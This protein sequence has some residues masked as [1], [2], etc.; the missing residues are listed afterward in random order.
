[1]TR[2]SLLIT[3]VLAGACTDGGTPDLPPGTVAATLETESSGNDPDD[4]AIFVH[5]T[6]PAL[7]RIIA[8]D[9]GLGIFFYDLDGRIVDTIPDLA[10][11]NVDLRHRVDIGEESLVLGTT[12]DRNRDILFTFGI[13]DDGHPVE[14]ART[15]E[16]EDFGDLY[17]SCMYRS[18]EGVLYVFV[19][20]KSGEY[21]Q[22]RIESDPTELAVS[23]THVRTFSLEGQPEG[24]VADDVASVVYL[25]EEDRGLF[26]IGA[27][28]DDGTQVETVDL[29]GQGRLIA[30]VEGMTIYPTTGGG[31]YLLVSSQGSDE[32]IV[33]DRSVPNAFVARFRIGDGAATDA[34]TDTDGIDVSPLALGPNF[35][36]GVFVAQDDHDDGFSRNF[37]IVRWDDI[38]RGAT[39]P[40]TIDTSVSP[41]GP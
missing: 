39:S 17:G 27:E 32:F 2:R 34:A 40:L 31:G 29:V 12:V 30:D 23:F 36:S 13:D 14:V 11:N 37:K 15:G 33:Y 26:R 35:P 4:P 38:A 20:A 18:P 8:T 24:C 1:M 16:I 7:S 19:N 25:G 5:P 9:K 41:Y 21:R 22:Y 3:L 6:D 28:P 10:P